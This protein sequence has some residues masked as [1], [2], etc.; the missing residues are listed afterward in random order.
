MDNLLDN[1][2]SPASE[3]EEK[4]LKYWQDRKIFEKT[5]NQTK[6]GKPFVF[7]DGPPFATG[8]PHYGHFLAG[9]IKDVIPRYQTMRG[10]FVRRQWGWDC[11]GLPVENLIEK[12]LNLKHKKD[13][14]EYGI[15]KFNEAAKNSVLRYDA[16]WKEQ[17]MKTGRFVD[18]E[19]SYKTMDASYTE[20]IWWAFKTL[21]DKGL[22]Y[23]GYKSM[24]VCPRCETP[25]A[26]AEV[27]G[28]YKDITDISVTVK[29]QLK[30]EPDTYLLAWTTTPWTLP[31]NAALA[32]GEEIEYMKV[33]AIKKLPLVTEAVNYKAPIGNTFN[34]EN[35]ILA[36]ERFLAMEESFKKDYAKYEII[37][38]LSSKDLI[39]KSYIPP[40]E[41]YFKDAELK[42][43]QN[44]WKIYPADFVTTETGTGIVHIAPAFGEDDMNL[45]KKF[46]L[47]F[48]QHVSMDGTFKKEVSDFAGQEVK[49]KDSH[50]KADIEIIKNL[51][52]KNILFSK[53]K[54]IH[55]YPHCWRCDSPLLNYAA[56]S[57]FIEV[58]KLRSNLLV[59][60]K[61]VKWVPEAIGKGRFHNWLS[62]ARDWAVSRA[63]FWGAPLPVWECDSCK[64]EKIVGSLEE[65]KKLSKKSANKYILMRHGQAE[66]NTLNVISCD[67]NNTHHLTET[68]KKQIIKSTGALKK[69]KIDLIASS[70]FARTKETALIIK[71]LLGLEESRVI[72]DDRLM[73]ANFG[74]FN[75]KRPIEYHKYFVNFKEQ[76][77]KR[78]PNGENLTDIKKRTMNFLEE[79]DEKYA[80]KNIL[81]ITHEYPAWMIYAAVSG[82]DIET[83]LLMKE[84]RGE[85]LKNAEMVDLPFSQF[86]HNNDYELDFHRPYVD[87][88]IFDCHCGGEMRRIPDVFDCWF[89]SGSM[90]YAQFHYPFENKKE[91]KKNFPADFIA[92]GV[93][94]TRGWFY[95]SMVLGL[96][97]FGK[98]PFKNVIVNGMILAEDGQKMSKRLKNYPDPMKIVSKYGADALRFTLLSMPTVKGEDASFS[99][100][101]VDETNKKLIVRLQNI[102]SFYEM[103]GVGEAKPLHGKTTT[104]GNILDK[105]ILTRLAETKNEV[106]SG[107][108]NYELDRSMK[109]ITEFID[110]MST[111]YIRRSRERFKSD[112]LKDKVIAMVTTRLTLLEL[113]KII[114]PVMP[115]L[116]EDIYLKLKGPKESVHLENW[117]KPRKLNRAEKVLIKDME[118]CRKIVSIAL[119]KRAEAK[120]KVRQPL[121]ALRVKN[122]PLHKKNK[123]A[124]IG[125]I[126]DETNV[127]QVAID[128]MIENEA[129]LDTN[130]T[131]ELKKEG[132]FREI[133]RFVQDIRKKQN[134]IPSEM[135][136]LSVRANNEGRMLIEQFENEIKKSATLQKI[137]FLGEIMPGGDIEGEL[138]VDGMTFR[139]ALERLG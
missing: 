41:Y 52:G 103:Y 63:R 105:W 47:P 113:S 79:I 29:F 31:G 26:N 97:L 111:W 87:K 136:I 67:K 37:A 89:E 57:W 69:K 16:E 66:N 86:P 68:G 135:A 122:L 80:N 112:N 44:G 130:I 22:V 20:S 92:E 72:F 15:E 75:G 81:I 123:E 109:P 94:Q 116:S 36:K 107:F 124:I 58:T 133:V 83:A 23:E 131:A 129:E 40:F 77:K 6:G 46:N 21:Y 115:F 27:V 134:F 127:K 53:E 121:G 55:A 100:R 33:R 25:L 108:D 60:N 70:P 2:K 104:S 73:E 138:S 64:E 38:E 93:D 71:D 119:E 11:H 78:A 96:G 4:I 42:N 19:K 50:Q 91:F 84:K 39:G 139:F 28:G 43:R 48:I 99:E 65:L 126:K 3:R 106:S 62:G 90:P 13:I 128:N 34:V 114:A 51:A 35:F 117:P 5:L 137:K 56:N 76:F 74:D 12:E 54:I 10:R 7:Y 45:G 18:M 30:D 14:E 120:I 125:L 9:T 49:P 95:S 110:D 88:I 1:K 82:A 98:S 132:Q 101:A 102:F 61:K 59:Q 24:H 17:I 32:V 85:F 8:L 118:T